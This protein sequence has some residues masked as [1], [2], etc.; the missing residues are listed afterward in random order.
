MEKVVLAVKKA[1][2]RDFIILEMGHAGHTEGKY[3]LT[4]DL[5]ESRQRT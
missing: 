1:G 4:D 2:I 3:T 5:W